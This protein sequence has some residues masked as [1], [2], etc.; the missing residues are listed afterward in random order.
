MSIH[1]T[2][3]ESGEWEGSGAGA[4]GVQVDCSITRRHCRSLITT[5]RS[6]VLPHAVSS[7][8]ILRDRGD[9]GDSQKGIQ[10]MPP[11]TAVTLMVVL[12]THRSE[13]LVRDVHGERH[14]V[15][16]HHLEST[17]GGP[18]RGEQIS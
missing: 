6:L 3:G 16:M 12:T 8:F 13:R 11:S 9:G 15:A 18:E 7:L 14:D 1:A 2:K 4:A 5:P 10:T 17:S